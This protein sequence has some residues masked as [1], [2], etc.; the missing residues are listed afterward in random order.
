[1]LAITSGYLPLATPELLIKTGKSAEACQHTAGPHRPLVAT[2]TNAFLT[3]SFKYPAAD[4]GGVVDNRNKKLVEDGVYLIAVQ[5]QVVP[6]GQSVA[7]YGDATT[8][9]P[10]VI[11][12]SR[13]SWMKSCTVW[14]S[15]TP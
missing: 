6:V 11:L 3:K 15:R 4:S 9:E 13:T 7:V 8:S 10:P 12:P 5:V 2:S 14:S 1:M